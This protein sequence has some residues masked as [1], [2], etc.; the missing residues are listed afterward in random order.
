MDEIPSN[1][2][3]ALFSAF[4]DKSKISVRAAADAIGCSETTMRRLLVA[5][6]KPSAETLKQSA[7]MIEIGFDRY[8]KLTQAEK[9][10]I[11]DAIGAIGGGT[12]GFAAVTAAISTLGISGLSAAGI[13]SGLAALGALVGGGMVVGVSVAAAI[14]IAAGALGYG[15]IVAVKSVLEKGRLDE[16]QYNPFWELPWGDGEAPVPAT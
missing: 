6:T 9:E 13:T 15:I 4:L 3:A 8:R 12:I 14:P 5:K 1:Q 2:W 10:K 16:E 7:V 11:S